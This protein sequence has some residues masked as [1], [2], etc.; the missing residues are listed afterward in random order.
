MQSIKGHFAPRVCQ[1]DNHLWHSMPRAHDKQAE[2]GRKEG[3]GGKAEKEIWDLLFRPS[4]AVVSC[5]RSFVI[6]LSGSGDDDRNGD[7]IPDSLLSSFLWPRGFIRQTPAGQI[8]VKRLYYAGQKSC[9]ARL[10]H[11]SDFL[12]SAAER[13][14]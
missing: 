14:L 1:F 5:Q 12:V 10:L 8:V 3:R 13:E 6:P 2:R 11:C 7:L 9:R 4:A